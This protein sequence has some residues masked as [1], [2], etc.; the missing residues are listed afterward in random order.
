MSKFVLCCIA[1]TVVIWASTTVGIRRV[2]M[3]F[4]P[5]Q[6][7][8]IR[9]A[10]ASLALLPVALF[11]R[12]GIPDKKDFWR[13]SITGII[14][15]GVCNVCLNIGLRIMSAATASFIVSTGPI[16]VA[17]LS[18]NFLKEKISV[19]GWIFIFIS[20]AGIGII[21]IGENGRLECT[22]GIL[23]VLLA[24]IAQAVYI[25]FQKPLFKKYSSIEVVCYS[26]WMATLTM[27]PFG[28]GITGRLNTATGTTLVA[29]I[30]L[31]VFP[32]AIAYLAWGLVLSRVLAS[33]AAPFLFMVPF[34]SVII[35]Y[36]W[37]HELP[38]PLALAGGL[39]ITL[40]L[41][42]FYRFEIKKSRDI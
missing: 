10:I 22:P 32:G 12:I 4:P 25:V 41:F 3:E 17:I 19:P 38:K 18:V 9:F 30:Y 21:I 35:G 13:I 14:G 15:I 8:F 1:V 24:A 7:L 42:F 27:I 28:W 33:R 39:V 5:F 6:L 36:F 2:V 26:I 23:F 37:L 40:G 34:F 29:V 16:F 11:S 31:G 20:F